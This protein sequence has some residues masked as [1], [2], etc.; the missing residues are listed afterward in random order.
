MKLTISNL[1]LYGKMEAIFY[2]L[3]IDLI[4]I[5]SIKSLRMIFKACY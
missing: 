2:H 4:D 1:S 5:Y 3:N